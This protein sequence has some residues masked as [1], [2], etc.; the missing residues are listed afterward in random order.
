MAKRRDIEEQAERWARRYPDS[1]TRLEKAVNL[2]DK[3]QYI[4]ESTWE[5]LG[6]SG[7]SYFV[8]V[9]LV[10]KISTCTCPDSMNGHRCKH[11]L[12]VAILWVTRK[13]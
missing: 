3:C 5:V 11:R 9:D 1:R 6:S 13:V 10:R 7:K 8:G 2:V 12:A 4:G